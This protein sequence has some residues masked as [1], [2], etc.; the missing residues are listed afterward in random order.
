MKKLLFRFLL[1][2]TISLL[3]ITACKKDKLLTDSGVSLVFSEDTIM[4]DTVFASVGSATQVFTVTNTYD[5][6]INIS[7][8]YLANGGSSVYRLNVNG[9]PGKSFTNVEIGAND[10]IWIF[11]EV[12]IDPNSSTLPF[13][14]E[15]AIVFNTNGTQQKLPLVAYG[16]N[17]HYFPSSNCGEQRSTC[18]PLFKLKDCNNAANKTLVWTNDLP[19]VIYG[20][21]ILDSGYT[22]TIE[23][24]TRVHFHNNSGLIVLNTARLIVNGTLTD[25]V[26]FQGDRLGEEFKDIPGQWDRIWFSSITSVNLNTCNKDSLFVSGAGPVGNK[27][28]HAI[29]KNGFVG[30]QVDTLGSNNIPALELDNTIIKNFA[31]TA[32]YGNG[33]FAVANNCVFANSG[34]YLTFLAIGGAYQFLQCTFANYWNNSNRSTPSML[35]NDYYVD[36]YSVLNIRPI[37]ALFGNCIIYG[38]QDNEIGYDTITTGNYID[39]KFDHCLYKIDN[40]TYN[41]SSGKYVSSIKNVEPFFADADNNNYELDT[42]YAATS[43]V[44]H[45]G[46]PALIQSIPMLGMDILEKPR[47]SPGGSNPDLGAYENQDH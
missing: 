40:E 41:G 20:Y 31:S 32:F 4:F 37:Q 14:V 35:F 45:S 42:A 25:P 21:A 19:Y 6:P 15:D 30:V 2:A 17:A 3:S 43:P 46:D 27:M 18:T 11:A 9:T 38:N 36:I 29:I 10:S 47:P 44:V 1:F 8:L 12:T 26:T 13:I 16:Q 23:A 22:L 28:N 39:V 33:A 34:E 7:S 5:Q 24:G